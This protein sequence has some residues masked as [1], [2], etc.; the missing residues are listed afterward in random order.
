MQIQRRKRREP[1]SHEENP[2]ARCSFTVLT[3]PGANS[4]ISTKAGVS[5]DQSKSTRMP[6]QAAREWMPRNVWLN[7]VSPR[8]GEQKNRYR[9][10]ACGTGSTRWQFAGAVAGIARRTAPCKVITWAADAGYRDCSCGGAPREADWPSYRNSPSL[11][12]QTVLPNPSLNP[13]LLRRLNN[14]RR[15]RILIS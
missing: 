2:R 7:S 6:P 10:A 3:K 4:M 9:L 11:T 15:S 13:A 8:M 1:N 12:M 5:A 14:S